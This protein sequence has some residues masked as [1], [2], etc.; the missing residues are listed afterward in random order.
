MRGKGWGRKH[1]TVDYVFK[2]DYLVLVAYHFIVID[3]MRKRKY[4]VDSNWTLAGYRGKKL[5]M[6]PLTIDPYPEHNDRYLEECKKLLLNKN[7]EY[8]SKY[9][10]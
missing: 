5:G 6:I 9:F 4:K 10:K 1:S 8:Y 3:E 2:Y 7:Y